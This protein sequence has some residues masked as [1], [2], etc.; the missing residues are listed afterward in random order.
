M[1][2]YTCACGHEAASADELADHVGEMVIPDD[3][4]GPDGQ[5][6]AE[7]ARPEPGAVGA[8]PAGL[9]CLCGYR[10]GTAAALDEHLLSVFTRPGAAG[11]S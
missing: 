10:P 7:A 11:H 3:D 4:T 6:H 2:D 1:P 5:R 9:R 8:D